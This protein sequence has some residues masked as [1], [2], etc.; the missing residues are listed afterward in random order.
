MKKAVIVILTVIMALLVFVPGGIAFASEAETPV[1]QET[2][3]DN[4]WDILQQALD[5]TMEN[6]YSDAEREKL[7]QGAL[8]GMM[9]ALDDPYS[10]YLSPDDFEQF[11]VSTEGSFSGVGMQVEQA[12]DYI[13]VVAPL[14]GTPAEKAGI[15]T[16]DIIIAVDAENIQGYT[17]EKAV[18]MIR[19]EIGSKVVL[20]I[21]RHGEEKP[22]EIEITRDEIELEVIQHRMLDKYIGYIFLNNFTANA[23]EEF[24]KALQELKQQGA[25]GLVFDLRSNPGGLL[26]SGLGVASEFVETGQ[27]LVHIVDKEGNKQSYI[28]INPQPE[29]MPVVVLVNGGSASASEIVAGA[30][31]DYDIADLVGEKTYG[32]A[33][34]QSL[35][36]LEDGGAIKLTTNHYF[37][38]KEREIQDVGLTPDYVVE[39]EEEQLEKAVELLKEKLESGY[40][41]INAVLRP[42]SKVVA[43]N[44]EEIAYTNAPYVQ[45]GVTMVPVRFLQE[46]FGASLLW[47][48][49]LESVV[50]SS[51]EIGM[52]V[53]KVGEKEVNLNGSTLNLHIQPVIRDGAVF[54]PLRELVGSLGASVNWDEE[55]SAVNVYHLKKK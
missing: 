11:Q 37:T 46:L 54:V 38:P 49:E 15:K 27:Q 31:Q 13:K 2:E 48:Q 21:L 40:E 23:P 24:Q 50:L 43:F 16:G 42:G 3:S 7:L 53:I 4:P 14:K 8:G 5:L 36:S 45:E 55:L 20:T 19:G 1:Q 34:V 35:F 29:K 26:T 51:D 47:D 30:L 17:L 25:V 10:Q 32:K 41:V 28:S 9:K 52:T 39:G 12:D 6:Y 18:S 33:S 22:F 44:G